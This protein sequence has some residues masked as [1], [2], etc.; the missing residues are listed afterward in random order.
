M[1]ERKQIGSKGRKQRSK[2]AE[3]QEVE[4]QKRMTEEKKK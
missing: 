3:E 1:K 2:G 4:R